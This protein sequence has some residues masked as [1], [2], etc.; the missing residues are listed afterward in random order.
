MI[1]DNGWVIEYDMDIARFASVKIQA[2]I[3]AA[4]ITPG[5]I[6]DDG[7]CTWK[8]ICP[9]DAEDSAR[10]KAEL[11]KLSGEDRLKYILE[12]KAWALGRMA[13]LATARW[14]KARACHDMPGGEAEQS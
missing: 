9:G 13:G 1:S 14:R 10:Q 12:F 4:R 8:G 2:K 7:Y 11:L 5:L 3:R 6:F